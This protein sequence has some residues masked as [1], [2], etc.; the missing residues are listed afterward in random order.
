M[1]FAVLALTTLA[2]AEPPPRAE[3]CRHDCAEKARESLWAPRK[4]SA[5]APE[6]LRRVQRSAAQACV[7]DESDEPSCAL[8]TRLTAALQEHELITKER[9]ADAA[10]KVLVA[11]Q[12]AAALVEDASLTD[13]PTFVA[14]W[15]GSVLDVCEPQ[16]LSSIAHASPA[17]RATIAT[18]ACAERLCPSLPAP[19]PGACAAL[20][21]G[22][23]QPSARSA[24]EIM[25]IAL[26]RELPKPV[27]SALVDAFAR[28]RHPYFEDAPAP[29]RKK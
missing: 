4:A 8:S 29:P 2:S 12:C 11:R 24:L 22:G 21:K 1:P 18:T 23:P 6:T 10:E 14:S 3:R 26:E 20:A 25:R 19:K 9:G 17:D 28:P 13:W 16:L 5:S 7:E 15:C 27:A